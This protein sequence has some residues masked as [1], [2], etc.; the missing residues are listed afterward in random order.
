MIQELLN[1]KNHILLTSDRW[2]ILR[3]RWTGKLG[4]TPLYVRAIV[5]EHDDKASAVQAGRELVSSFLAEMEGRTPETR[6]Q[7][8]VRRPGYR[9]LKI[10]HRAERRRE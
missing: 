10:C 5:S 3:A 7:A 1:D 8:L 9:S 4:A 2:H 6:D